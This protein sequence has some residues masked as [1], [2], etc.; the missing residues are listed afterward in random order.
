MRNL[1]VNRFRNHEIDSVSNVLQ[2]RFRASDSRRGG[3]EVEAAYAFGD[4]HALA[5]RVLVVWQNVRG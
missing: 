5:T 1:H 3:D 4:E 2:E